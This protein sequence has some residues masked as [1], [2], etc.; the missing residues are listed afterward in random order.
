MVIVTAE[1]NMKSYLRT[2][3]NEA[4]LP[5]KA[6]HWTDWWWWTSQRDRGH[7]KH[8]WLTMT[9]LSTSWNERAVV[10]CRALWKW[11]CDTM[12]DWLLSHSL[13]CW[14]PAAEMHS[15]SQKRGIIKC[16]CVSALAPLIHSSLGEIT[17]LLHW[18]LCPDLF[19]CSQH[20]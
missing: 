13:G 6:T 15:L 10:P 8:D 17:L 4:W 18:E 19:C 14:W 3:R 11:Q 7:S 16:C 5:L 1:S 12:T 20:I 2:C 9:A